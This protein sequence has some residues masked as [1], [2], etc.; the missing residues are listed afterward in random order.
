MAI[1]VFSPNGTHVAKPTLEVARTSADCAGKTVVVTSALTAAQ[2]NITAAWPADRKLEVKKGGS[3]GN[4]TAFTIDGS[5]SDVLYQV[6]TGTGAVT[7]LKTVSPEAFGAIGDGI[8]DDTGA[9]TKAISAV[10]AKGTIITSPTKVYKIMASVAVGSLSVVVTGG[11]TMLAGADI[12]MFT[13]DTGTLEIRDMNFTT[14]TSGTGTVATGGAYSVGI[15][16]NNK[17]TQFHSGF[18]GGWSASLFQSNDFYSAP[19]VNGG[20]AIHFA[21]ER[22]RV[23]GNK[24]Y[25]HR[26]HVYLSGA[27]GIPT[28]YN[29]VSNNICKVAGFG[30]IQIYAYDYQ[31]GCRYNEVSN[32]IIIDDMY[33]PIKVAGDVYFNKVIGNQI[34]GYDLLPAGYGA[35][36]VEGGTVSPTNNTPAFNL[37]ESNTISTTVANQT[38]NPAI[39]LVTAAHCT[40]SN[41]TIIH[42]AT[43]TTL[44]TVGV[45][46]YGGASVGNNILNNT[47]TRSA[48]F[49][50]SDVLYTTVSNNHFD[51]VTGMNPTQVADLYYSVVNGNTTTFVKVRFPNGATSPDVSA[52]EFFDVVNSAATSITTFSN[53]TT[54]KKITVWV[55]DGLTTFVNGSLILKGKINYTPVADTAITFIKLDGDTTG[56][57]EV[58]RS[59]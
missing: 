56:W 1:L 4:T 55:R 40:V 33:V 7:G 29:I 19:D 28:N 46:I 54:G 53:G 10:S 8:A 20:Y 49:T 43:N 3:I 2:S 37:I 27:T 17:V 23:L 31:S 25:G 24:F 35:I 50:W 52:C 32:N 15:F 58:S 22:N 42:P 36:D 5:F 16:V 51:V 34:K 48:A 26:H 39:R 41:N 13:V 57:L 18:T 6:F 44:A 12:S 14:A 38:T 47:F 9:F 21:G 11:G 45:S 59:Q 30:A